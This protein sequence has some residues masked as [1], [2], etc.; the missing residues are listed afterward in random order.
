MLIGA[1]NEFGAIRVCGDRVPVMIKI[2]ILFLMIIPSTVCAECRLT[3]SEGKVQGV[4]WGND[5]PVVSPPTNNKKKYHTKK[6]VNSDLRKVNAESITSFM[7]GEELTFML[8]R[9]HQ[10]GYRG[11]AQIAKQ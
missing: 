10:D 1:N 11:K 5:G 2:I 6:K 7:T 8:A 3:E 4:C 9:N